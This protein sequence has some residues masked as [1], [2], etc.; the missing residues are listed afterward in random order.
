MTLRRSTSCALAAAVAATALTVMPFTSAPRAT[1]EPISG[2]ASP[3]LVTV[4][5]GGSPTHVDPAQPGVRIGDRVPTSAL[6]SPAAVDGHPARFDRRNRPL[7]SSPFS[8]GDVLGTPA[9]RPGLRGLVS[10]VAPSCT[11]TGQ[12]GNRVQVLYAVEDRHA[13]RYD[14]LVE[15]LRSYVADVD[16]TFA[17]SSRDAGR[18]VRWVSD[19]ACVPAVDHVVLPS[20]TLAKPDLVRLK[21]ALA[22]RGYD[23]PNR[24]YLVFADASQLCGI[25]DVYLDDRRSASNRNNGGVPMYAR[26]DT[27]CWSVPAGGHSTPAHELM[28]L[29]GAVQPSAPHGTAY[30]HCTDEADAMCYADG[31]G[32][33]MRSVCTQPDDEQLFDC[34]R[35]DYFDPRP[36]PASDYLRRHW[37][38]AD[39]SFLDRLPPAR[40]AAGLPPLASIS[41]PSRLRPGLATNLRLRADRPVDVEWRTSRRQCVLDAS[42]S[43]AVL[44]CPSD[45]GGSVTVTAT[46]TAEDGTWARVNRRITLSGTSARLAV[47][48]LALPQVAVNEQARLRANVKYDG[49]RVWAA[50]R[51]QQYAGK[52]RGWVT[53]ETALTDREGWVEFVARR[54]TSGERT[55]R[56]LVRTAQGSGW[57]TSVSPS[58]AVAVV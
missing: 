6:L 54:S 13:D 58:R 55:Y 10:H 36:R 43:T 16:D 11:G 49:A 37:N 30:G 44:Q 53:L 41:G 38:T 50:V 48:L 56:V 25:G 26:I 34:R 39:S 5:D 31:D 42:G 9:G 1:A 21:T 12:D 33:R 28:H 51:L 22:A 20:G 32:Q 2:P 40:S 18:R 46:A 29:L 27:P 17:L 14:E 3:R 19:G 47:G 15:A 52:A 57:E 24:K 45:V 4:A 7:S 23:A 35:D 8:S